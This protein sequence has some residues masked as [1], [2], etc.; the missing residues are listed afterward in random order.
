M[1]QQKLSDLN[2]NAH[3]KEMLAK[4]PIKEIIHTPSKSS[5]KDD[6]QSLKAREKGMAIPDQIEG[7]LLDTIVVS[8]PEGK[9]ISQHAPPIQGGGVKS[10]RYK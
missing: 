9:I 3:L 8:N 2:K 7:H 1:P 4:E 5:M 10:N 6:I